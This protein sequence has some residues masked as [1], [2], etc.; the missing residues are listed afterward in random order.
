M[1][2]AGGIVQLAPYR[3]QRKW[4]SAP[5]IR[6]A[7]DSPLEGKGFERLVSLA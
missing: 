6:F 2:A 4:D 3:L 7:L 5:K 1:G